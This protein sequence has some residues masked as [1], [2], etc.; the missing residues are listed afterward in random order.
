M[1]RI[2]IV[3]IVIALAFGV[4]LYLNKASSGT[5]IDEIERK[6]GSIGELLEERE[7]RDGEVVF[8][9]RQ[10]GERAPVLSADYVNK[11]FLGWKWAVGGGH[12]LPA[13][14][15][16][17][18][19]WSFQYMDAT[20]GSFFNHSPFPLVFG[21]VNNPAITAVTIKSVKTGQ[22]TIAD[23]ITSKSNITL[24]YAFIEEEQGKAFDLTGLAKSG[25]TVSKKHI[26]DSE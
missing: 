7:V 9:M 24:W 12:S 3:L 25:E 14:S 26:F 2:V 21:T 5:A 11:S 13:A 6:R 23:L 4:K 8:Y 16:N 1:K 15:G 17:E 20:K 10:E 22:E 19:A 18:T